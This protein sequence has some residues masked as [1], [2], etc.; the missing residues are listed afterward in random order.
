MRGTLGELSYTELRRP[1]TYVS[2]NKGLYNGPVVC[3]L[4][5]ESA[6]NTG[7]YSELTIKST[8]NHVTNVRPTS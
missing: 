5:N 4:A 2:K 7:I 6:T 1:V 8:A 3:L